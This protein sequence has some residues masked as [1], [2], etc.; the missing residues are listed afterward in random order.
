[1][2]VGLAGFV[3]TATIVVEDHTDEPTLPSPRS[4]IAGNTNSRARR[5][6]PISV[7]PQ[8]GAG[9]RSRRH[10]QPT[11]PLSAQRSVTIFTHRSC[12]R[13]VFGDKRIIVT[14][15]QQTR[16]ADAPANM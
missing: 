1:M 4:P 5:A 15:A 7:P 9:R 12:W 13:A 3:H 2:A 6:G 14:G 11:P 8:R 16:L 10:S